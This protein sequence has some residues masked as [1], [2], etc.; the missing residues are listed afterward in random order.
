MQQYPLQNKAAA[1]C[2]HQLDK[3]FIWGVHRGL[4]LKCQRAGCQL[5]QKID[6]SE[7]AM[8]P[9][10]QTTS[11]AWTTRVEQTRIKICK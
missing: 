5:F 10:L 3:G 4:P 6:L 1:C 2:W 7:V 8:T 9:S 11:S